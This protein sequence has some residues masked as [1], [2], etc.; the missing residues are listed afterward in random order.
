M[1]QR[2]CVDLLSKK[3]AKKS[4]ISA[5]EYMIFD[6]KNMLFSYES[7]FNIFGSYDTKRVD[8][9]DNPI[10]NLL[11]TKRSSVDMSIE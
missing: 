6:W 10:L 5:R 9:N 3:L 2:R 4:L 11:I 1:V 8:E 7:I